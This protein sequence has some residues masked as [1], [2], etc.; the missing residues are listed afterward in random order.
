MTTIPRPGE[1]APGK[2]FPP[3][4]PPSIRRDHLLPP[5]PHPTLTDPQSAR[6]FPPRQPHSPHE[7]G[8]LPQGPGRP[9]PE[10]LLD[11]HPLALPPLRHPGHPRPHPLGP[12]RFQAVGARNGSGGLL[13]AGR[14]GRRVGDVRDRGGV[15]A[16]DVGAGEVLC[17]GGGGEESVGDDED[18]G[19]EGL[20]A[21]CCVGGG[22]GGW[23]GWGGDGAVGMR[24]TLDGR[25]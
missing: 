24:D 13:R 9:T 1:H 22:W 20:G 23:G 18:W 12:G 7:Q 25:A 19:E 17:G 16:G 15:G 5:R 4:L 14:R 8:L 2:D 10:R 6:N 11:L 3:P 21:D